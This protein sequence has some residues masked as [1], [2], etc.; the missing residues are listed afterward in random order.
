MPDLDNPF[1]TLVTFVQLIKEGNWR[2]VAAFVLMIVMFGL[3]KA[4]NKVRFFKGDRG[5]A[6]LLLVLALAGS[7]SAALFSSAAL[8]PSLIVGAVSVAFTSAGGYTLIKRII[9]PKDAEEAEIK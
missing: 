9:W 6:V 2:L 3:N 5:G 1:E 4:R 7:V 8:D